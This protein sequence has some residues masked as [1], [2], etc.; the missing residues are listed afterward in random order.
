MGFVF[1][2]RMNVLVYIIAVNILLFRNDIVFLF[3][4]TSSVFF[5]QSVAY[6]V[7]IKSVYFHSVYILYI[8]H[9]MCNKRRGQDF[10][11]KIWH[12]WFCVIWCWLLEKSV[13][14][15][16]VNR[17]NETFEWYYHAFH[18]IFTSVVHQQQNHLMDKNKLLVAEFHVNIHVEQKI[19]KHLVLEK[20]TYSRFTKYSDPF[21]LL[22]TFIK[23]Q[24]CAKVVNFFPLINLKAI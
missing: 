16:F 19:H 21:T 2:Y 5:S 10:I 15:K 11:F 24:L 1:S 20:M 12:F 9:H 17:C 13:K 4:R 18:D 7:Y 22:E 6:I 8:L 3:K 23:L 14:C